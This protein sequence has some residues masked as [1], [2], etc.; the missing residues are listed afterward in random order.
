M[1][2]VVVAIFT[3]ESE[4]YQALA[5][6]RQAPATEGYTV[7]Q[8]ALVKRTDG[9]V[10]AL[11]GF[12]TG[13]L[14]SNDTSLGM[15][16]GSFIG[17]LGG[18]LGVLLGAGAGALAGGAM[19]AADTVDTVSVMT[20]VAEKL[21]DDE[22][23]LIAL[24]QEDEPAFDAPFE[25]F[26]ATII[27]YDALAV[28]DEVNRARDVEADLAHQARAK[29]RADQF[30]AASADAAARALETYSDQIPVSAKEALGMN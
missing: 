30:E 5:E 16:I 21:Y 12:D 17:I 25:K 20:T 23:A 7:A 4:G 2:N 1:E 22:V 26:D 10:K 14:T 15:I 8:A 6:L 28:V 19:D 24:V 29:M 3:A 9:A 13:L 11:D 27:R 18:P